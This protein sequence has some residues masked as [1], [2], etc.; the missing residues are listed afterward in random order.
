M[1]G[2]RGPRG[3]GA[4][5]GFYYHLVGSSFCYVAVISDRAKFVGVYHICLVLHFVVAVVGLRLFVAC[6]EAHGTLYDVN[7]LL[8]LDGTVVP[9][10]FGSCFLFFPFW[11]FSVF[12]GSLLLLVRP[13]IVVRFYGYLAVVL[14]YSLGSPSEYMVFGVQ[15][16][17]RSC[18]TLFLSLIHI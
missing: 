2:H 5:F 6:F 10:I 16:M 4:I 8:P 3:F 1:R 14:D 11:S 9:F 17:C 7:E 12:S 15:F 18:R 13:G